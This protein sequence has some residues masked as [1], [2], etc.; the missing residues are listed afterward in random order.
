MKT[1]STG[2]PSTVGTYLKIAKFFGENAENFMQTYCDKYGEDEEVIAEESQML[3][4]LQSFMVMPK[5]EQSEIDA[6]LERLGV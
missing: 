2:E 1:I 5:M 3:Y 6:Y 4:L